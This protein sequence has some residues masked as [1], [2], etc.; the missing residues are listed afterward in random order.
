MTATGRAIVLHGDALHL[1]LPDASVDTIITSPPYWSLRSYQDGGRHYEGQMGG[2]ATPAEYID[3]LIACTREWMR[4]LCPHGSMFVNLGD[5]WNAYNGNRGDG[6]I[7]RNKIRQLVPGGAGLD[8]SGLRPKTLI[9]LPWRYAL[10]CIDDLGLILRAEI[11]WAKTNGMPESVTDRVRRSHETWFHLVKQP[12][13][14]SAVDEIREPTSGYQRA[15]GATRRVPGGQRPRA[16]ADTCNPLGALPGSV[17]EI[18]T[19]PLVVPAGLGLE[20]FAAFPPEWP[21]RLILGWSPSGICGRCGEGRRPIVNRETVPHW[22]GGTK[23]ARNGERTARATEPRTNTLVSVSGEVCACPD[24]SAPT[25]PAVVLDPFGGTGTTAMV[26][27]ALGRTGI[28]VDLSADYCRIARWRTNDRAQLAKV[29]DKPA[30]PPEPDDMDP[31][32]DLGDV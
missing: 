12:R 21:R 14:F 8:V 15:P 25:C 9:G 16:M 2:E 28:S 30:P 23:G 32:F 24:N 27:K 6:T 5:K 18:P 31:L 11:V 29:L 20:H 22:K 10:R 19:A 7:Q 17:W 1:P 13:Y 3:N 26:A 4:V